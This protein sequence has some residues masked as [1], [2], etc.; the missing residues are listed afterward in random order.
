M[1]QNEKLVFINCDL[2]KLVNKY[3][4]QTLMFSVLFLFCFV[5]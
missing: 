2:D 5:Q 1:T 4:M 3:L